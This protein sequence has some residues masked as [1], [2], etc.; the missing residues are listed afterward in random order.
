MFIWHAFASRGFVSDSWAFLFSLED[1]YLVLDYNFRIKLKFGI[2]KSY[3]FYFA[4]QAI[5]LLRDA[6]H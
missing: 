1:L 4:P 2:A 5:L 6:M 3:Y